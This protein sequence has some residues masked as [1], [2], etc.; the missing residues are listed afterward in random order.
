MSEP[1]ASR[2][3]TPGTRTDY[4]EIDS[5]AV[6]GRFAISVAL[7]RGYGRDG[8]D[9][10]LVYATDGNLVAPLA[11]ALRG[12]LVDDQ[13]ATR[14][15][16]YVQVSIGY[17]A[18]DAARQLILRNR[19][20]VPP[21]EEVPGFMADHARDRL[22]AGASESAVEDFLAAQR[23]ARA[24]A[25]LAFVEDELHPEISR[26]YRFRGDDVGLFGFS[27]GG[28]FTLYA[29]TAGSR[30][31]S[32]FGACSPGVVVPDS[33]IYGLYDTL[34]SRP[35]EAERHL[36]LTVNAYEMFGPVRLYR[37]LAIEV[38]RLYDLLC[39]RPLPGLRVTT[40]LLAG[41]AH[42][43]GLADAYRSFLR[44]CYPADRA[45][46]EDGNPDRSR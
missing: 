39:E 36:H 26:R 4:F 14:V 19:D 16:P 40:E 24:D 44:T 18:E 17:T 8:T 21:G 31:F 38:L 45:V 23:G 33:R 32:R 9:P 29:L 43:T 30:L 22:G 41:E 11:D 10:P 5:A 3:A 27:Y 12:G 2:M 34:R 35:A 15:E 46:A 1:T 25:F 6:G 42:A 20:L 37:H 28:L 7:P 13:A